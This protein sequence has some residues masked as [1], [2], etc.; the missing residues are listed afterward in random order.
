MMT[1]GSLS[2]NWKLKACP[3][4]RDMRAQF[5]DV[6]TEKDQGRK[7]GR[8]DGVAFGDRF[9]RVADCVELVSD[10]AHFLRQIAH[11][12]DAAGVVRDRTEGV[13]RDDDSGHREHAHD[14]DGDAVKPARNES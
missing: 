11:H 13:E 8:S 9:H 2:E 3:L 10:A 7:A 6:R 5:L 1:F 12:G 14:R 4:A